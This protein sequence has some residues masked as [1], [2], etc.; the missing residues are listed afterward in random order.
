MQ[1][2]LE[3]FVHSL[4]VCNI[5]VHSLEDIVHS[6]E[7]YCSQLLGVCNIPVQQPQSVPAYQHTSVPAPTVRAVTGLNHW[8]RDNAEVNIVC[9]FFRPHRP[10]EMSVALNLRC[11]CPTLQSGALFLP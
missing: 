10:P 5:P 11:A 9:S 6:L 7:E 8:R 2:S 4:G 1:H 3:E